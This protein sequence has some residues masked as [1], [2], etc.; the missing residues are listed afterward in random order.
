MRM[1]DEVGLD[2]RAGMHNAGSVTFGVA[3]GMRGC[4]LRRLRVCFNPTVLSSVEDSRLGE[5]EQCGRLRARQ[6][7]TVLFVAPF[8]LYCVEFL[9]YG[10]CSVFDF[11]HIDWFIQVPTRKTYHVV[12]TS[13]CYTT[14]ILHSMHTPYRTPLLFT[15]T[16]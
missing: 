10:T 5:H 15:C 6:A 8:A 7:C 11:A 14:Y 13:R 3:V 1:R 9:E 16:S 2:V 12:P 4:W